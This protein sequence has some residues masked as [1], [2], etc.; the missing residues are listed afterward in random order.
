MNNSDN[1]ATFKIEMKRLIGGD[2][3]SNISLEDV[4]ADLD[5]VYFADKLK[6]NP[7]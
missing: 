5:A 2:R 3:A 1:Y 4:L 7:A 6:A